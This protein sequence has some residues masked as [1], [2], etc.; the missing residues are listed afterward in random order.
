MIMYELFCPRCHKRIDSE[1]GGEQIIDC[2]DPQDIS[3]EIPFNFPT[4]ECLECEIEFC[5]VGRKIEDGQIIF[6]DPNVSKVEVH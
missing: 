3:E 6:Q 1:C 4:Y 5:I 2:A